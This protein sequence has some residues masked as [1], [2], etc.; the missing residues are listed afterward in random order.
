VCLAG[1][2][3]IALT[4]SEKSVIGSKLFA[5]YQA[6]LGNYQVKVAK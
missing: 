2:L 5:D 3:L 6:L 1:F 4:M